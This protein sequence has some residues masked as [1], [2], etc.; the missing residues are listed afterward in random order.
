MP[1]PSIFL[2]YLQNYLLNGLEI[3][4][5]RFSDCLKAVLKKLLKIGV[6]KAPNHAL[7]S[8]MSF[9]KNSSKIFSPL[10]LNNFSLFVISMLSLLVKTI[11]FENS[12]RRVLNLA[13][14]W[15]TSY[16]K[17]FQKILFFVFFNSFSLFI[18][19]MLCLQV[20]TI[21]FL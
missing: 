18:I 17:K 3:F 7:S 2:K 14:S 20:K 10:F 16:Q 9:Q 21:L 12:V 11:F 1:H 19:S 5:V 15:M 6:R 8:M 4:K 13:L